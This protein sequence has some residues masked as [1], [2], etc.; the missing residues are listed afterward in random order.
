[1][2]EN[3]GKGVSCAAKPPEEITLEYVYREYSEE[4]MQEFAT[5]SRQTTCSDRFSLLQEGSKENRS[6][7][8]TQK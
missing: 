3:L 8:H 1:M 7:R 5:F 2:V 6:E 4:I